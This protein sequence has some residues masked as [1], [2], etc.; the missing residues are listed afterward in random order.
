MLN[1]SSFNAYFGDLKSGNLKTHYTMPIQRK[2]MH[3]TYLD[4]TC[5]FLVANCLLVLNSIP[6]PLKKFLKS[7]KPFELIKNYSIIRLFFSKEWLKKIIKII[8]IEYY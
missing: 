1:E 3:D 2:L 7:D 8:F 4:E 6:C 5:K